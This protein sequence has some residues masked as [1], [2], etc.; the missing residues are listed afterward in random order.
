MPGHRSSAILFSMENK[1]PQR[2]IA[3][4]VSVLSA[5]VVPFM[6]SSVNIALPSIGREFSL[7]AVMLNWIATAYILSAAMLLL[8]FGKVADMRGRARMLISGITV[9]MLAS[10]GCALA[11]SETVLIACR[12]AQGMGGAIIFGTST[13][14]L[15]SVFPANERGKVLGYTVASTYFGLSCGP[16][17]GGFLVHNLG[18]RSI[19][20]VTVPLCAAAF[21]AAL[22]LDRRHEPDLKKFDFAGSLLYGISLVSLVYGFSLLPRVSGAVSV[23]LGMAGIAGFIV[24]ENTIP[25]PLLNI[26]LFV[27]NRVFAFSNLSALIN[28]SAT[29]ATGF[30]LSLYLQYVKGLSPQHAGMVLIF[31]PVVMALFSPFAGRLSDRI[32]PRIVSSAGMALCCT[33]IFLL[34]RIQNNTGMTFIMADLAVLGLGFALF[35][36]PNTNAVMS[37][38]ERK[39]YG[40]ASAT[41][42]TMRMVGQMLS[43][44]VAMLVIALFVG[45]VK[46]TPEYFPQ[47][48]RSVQVCFAIFAVLCFAGI[49]SS[50]VRGKLR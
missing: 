12:F 19:F 3:L 41:L 7:D 1:P 18:W 28:Y 37:S 48:L 44:G 15:T 49:F 32:E 6:G 50:L 16:V 4:T 45:K 22:R 35:S 5:F 46:I 2:N 43:M 9:M 34:S 21:I 17:L 14:I 26:S 39:D 10:L 24:L 27:K 36:S 29:F 31:Q 33:G 13:A 30:L 23:I 8:P 25:N 40:V 47:F 11:G 38:V 20:W 42:G